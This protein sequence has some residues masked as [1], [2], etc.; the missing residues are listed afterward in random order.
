MLVDRPST[1][2][3]AFRRHDQGAEKMKLIRPRFVI[4]AALF[5]ALCPLVAAAQPSHPLLQRPTFNGNLIVFSYAGDLWTVDRNGGHAARLTTGTGIETDPVFSPDGSMIAFTGE[6]D[7]N[8]DVFVVPASGGVP[9]RLTYHPGPD[10]A[11][12]WTPDGK[13]VTFR[14]TRESDSPRYTKLFKVSLNGGL[15]T[16]LPLPMAFSGKFSAD[17]KYFA[18]SPVGGGSP[19]NYLSY[20][21]WRN[22]RGGLA[23]SVWVADMATLDVVKVPREGPNDFNA[24]WVDKEVYFLSDRNGPISLFRFDPATKSVTEVVKNDGADIRS[25]SAG[26]GGIVYDR[27]GELF[28][29]DTASGQTHQINVDVNADLPDVR[30]RISPADH[31]IQSFAISPTGVRAVFEAHGDILTVPAKESATRDITSTPGVMEREPAWSPDGQ[32]IAYF[33]DESGQYALHISNQTGAGEVKKFPLANDATYYFNPVW[34]PDSKLIA[35]HD[36]KLE[37]WLLDTVTRKAAV[38]DKAVAEDTDYDAAWSPD[39]KWIAYTQ[40]VSNRFHALFLHS[41]AS[42]KSTQITDGMSDVRFPAFDRGGKYLYFTESTNYGTSTSGLD[43]SSDEFDVTRSVYGLALAADTASPVAPQNEDEK[44]PEAGKKIRIK[45]RTRR[46]K[47]KTKTRR[48]K[49]KTK[50]KIKIE[51]KIRKIRK[52]PVT[53]PIKTNPAMRRKTMPG[54]PMTAASQ[55]KRKNPRSRSR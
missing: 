14:S 44:T 4:F 11:V 31:D 45:T 52:M 50:T 54:K 3:H 20:V 47:T 15:A 48:I 2:A 26:P 7:G 28:L 23:S 1:R 35:F 19:F 30:A 46:I 13:Y 17:G 16:A 55:T 43:M 27:F 37:I 25:A 22:Y 49:I 33:S 53:T 5:S 21:A 42:G 10:A 8:T 51:I 34:S 36:N 6:Y 38:I 18:Y 12:G 29:Y 24:I 39:S 40:T 41:I 32:S 9:K